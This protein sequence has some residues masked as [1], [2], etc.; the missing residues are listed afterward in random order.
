MN[1]DDATADQLREL[2]ATEDMLTWLRHPEAVRTLVNLDPEVGGDYACQKCMS[3]A[4]HLSSCVVAAAWRALGDPRGAEDIER[5]HVEAIGEDGWRARQ[6]SREYAPRRPMPR[7]TADA[8][9][10]DGQA[11]VI[12]MRAFNE[13]AKRVF[14]EEALNEAFR[15]PPGIIGR[16]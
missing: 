3:Y 1:L 7:V 9:V 12:D 15:M 4:A 16:K 14:S 8:N 5:A 13:A 2:G 10:K 6:R 11:F